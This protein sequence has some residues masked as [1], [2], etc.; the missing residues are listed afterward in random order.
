MS[1]VTNY[2]IN[3]VVDEKMNL[4]LAFLRSKYPLLKDSELIKMALSGLYTELM[5][6]LP[7]YDLSEEEEES[8][9]KALQTKNST[10]KKFQS[11]SEAMNYLDE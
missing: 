6:Q 7:I 2:R 10:K 4:V 8:L 3:L 5:E 11:V 1:T 9:E